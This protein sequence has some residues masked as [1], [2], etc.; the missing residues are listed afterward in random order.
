MLVFCFWIIS[1]N[2]DSS[3]EFEVFNRSTDAL[4]NVQISCTGCKNKKYIELENEDWI[5]FTLDMSGI[6]KSDGNYTI[7]FKRKG[8]KESK[9]FGYYTN[10]YPIN[11]KYKIVIWEKGVEIGEK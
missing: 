11:N 4:K 6:P 9:G 5:K 8:K 1:C 7:E 2:N 10:G 3:V